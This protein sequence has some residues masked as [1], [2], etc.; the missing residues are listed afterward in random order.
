MQLIAE[1]IWST[2]QHKIIMQKN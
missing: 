1:Y 2:S